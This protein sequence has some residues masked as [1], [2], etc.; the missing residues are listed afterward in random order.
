VR[1]KPDLGLIITLIIFLFIFALR[2][3][4]IANSPAE[5]GDM[6]RQPDTESIARNF[7]EQRFNIFYPQF[8]YDGPLPNY[9]QLEFQVTTFII[10]V[11]YK[12]FGHSYIIARLVPTIFFMFSA[13]YL[14]LICR[15][16]YDRQMAWIAVLIYGLIPLNLFYSRAI[17]PESALLFFFLGAYYHF[18]RWLDEENT[19]HLMLSGIYT[20]LAISQKTPAVFIGLA[21]LGLC[22]TKYKGAFLKRGVLWAF[23]AVALFPPYLYLKWSERVSEF[24]FVTWI[25][26]KHIF[27]KVLGSAFSPEAWTFFKDTFPE[28]FTAAV[29]ALCVLGL[30]FH[31]PKKD[32]AVL[33]LTL[34]VFIET[35]LI[36]SV[37]KFKYY[38]IFLTPVA[39]LLAGKPLWLAAKKHKLGILLSAV[40]IGYLFYAG[41]EITKPYYEEIPS[42][43][44]F[45][46]F[47]DQNTQEDDLVVI[48]F[49]DPARL[50]LSSRRGWRANIDL[51][52]HIPRDIEGELRFFEESG[53]KYFIVKDGY[54]Y[55][56][57][58]GSYF[59]YL[60][61]NYQKLSF[62]DGYVMYVLDGAAEASAQ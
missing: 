10:A 47:I 34:A 13:L 22:L 23:A 45:A 38:L 28:A 52:D 56:D 26:Q 43:T 8:N 42:I 25:A 19:P 14:Y 18:L 21:M 20:A 46:K 16:T 4:Y 50:S 54:I 6:W 27:P 58:D 51:Y 2:L 1:K 7:A 15:D 59:E 32:A 12:L 9:I 39:A 36:V 55:N 31:R 37:I 61:Q 29:L 49:L 44:E 53:A 41:T 35:L 48:P 5:M 33:F 57:L 62:D 40:F 30:A 17:M 3:P 11:L 60:E 24:K